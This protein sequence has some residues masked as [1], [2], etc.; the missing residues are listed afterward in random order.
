[1]T[2]SMALVEAS[3]AS[4]GDIFAERIGGTVAL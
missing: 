3:G 4:G 2:E 1:M